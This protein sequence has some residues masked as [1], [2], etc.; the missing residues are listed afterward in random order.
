MLGKIFGDSLNKSSAIVSQFYAFTLV[1]DTSIKLFSAE[2]GP[3]IL[4]TIK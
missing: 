4:Q 2:I 3:M 1:R